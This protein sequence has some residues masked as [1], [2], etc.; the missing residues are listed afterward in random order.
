MPFAGIATLFQSLVAA[1]QL[2]SD[3]VS[4]AAG[5]HQRV[6][7]A[8][9]SW[10]YDLESST[11]NSLLVGS[12]GKD[13]EIRPPSDVDILFELPSSVYERI[14]RRTGNVQS[15]LLQ[16]VKGVLERTFP[17]TTMRGDGQVV[18]VP[19][20][21]YAVEVLPTF[22]LTDGKYWYPDTN[23]GGKWKTTDPT[24]E[25][26]SLRQSNERTG[27]KATH[28]IKLAKAWRSTRGV[29]IKSFLL[30]LMAVGFLDSWNYNRTSDGTLSSYLYYDYMMRDFFRYMVSKAKAFFWVP[31]TN[32]LVYAGDEWLAQARFAFNTAERAT[33]FGSNDKYDQAKAEW[34]NVFGTYL[35]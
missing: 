25:K 26:A 27:G 20:A 14:S 10:Y 22:R 6:R 35:P 21:S 24:A 31:G 3:Q 18:R 23:E 17:T 16:E 2:T 30:E 32:D 15:H 1:V 9:N 13:T 19:F 11:A 4:D 5:K 28:L 8:L 12:Y 33:A 7:R 29:R 34:R